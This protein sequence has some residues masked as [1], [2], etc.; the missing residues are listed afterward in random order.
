MPS[1][2][3]MGPK[4]VC[5]RGV[6]GADPALRWAISCVTSVSLKARTLQSLLCFLW[7]CPEYVSLSFLVRSIFSLWVDREM[8]RKAHEPCDLWDRSH[9][10][11]AQWPLCQPQSMERLL[12]PAPLP[13]TG[14]GDGVVRA[15][16]SLFLCLSHTPWTC[17]CPL[18]LR[19]GRD[20]PGWEGWTPSGKTSGKAGWGVIWA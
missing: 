13:P 15:W 18:G 2:G 12:S 8:I 4:V 11:P 14:G 3:P 16:T 9:S 5:D 19:D 20:W 1:S 7:A 10:R 6:A 17:A